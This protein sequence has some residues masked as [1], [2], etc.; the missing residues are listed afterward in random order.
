MS[1]PGRPSSTLGRLLEAAGYHVGGRAEGTVAVRAKDHRAVVIV[2]APRLPAEVETLFPADAVH[3]TIVYDDEPGAVARAIAAERGIEILEPTT[4]GGALGELLLPAA[5]GPLEV[6]DDLA[7][8]S[9]VDSPFTLA[10]EGQ[11]TV[12]PRIDR[13]E[14]EVLAGVEAPSFTLRLVPFFVAGYRVRPAS[15]HGESG[16]VLRHLVAVNA[17]SRSAEIWEDADRELVAGVPEPHQRLAPQLSPGQAESIAVDAIRRHH[18]VHVDH[19]EQHGG[20][21]VIETRRIPPSRD[22]LRLGPF[23]LLYVPHWYAESG[24][25]RVVLDAVTGRRASASDVG[26]E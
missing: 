20:A 15:P 12:R 22:D 25:G 1:K 17:I 10:P 11:R 7:H 3:R 24:E 5:A 9:P 21:L 6:E 4:L 23:V 26:R 8:G 14:A 16:S 19:T 13:A 18:T 2:S